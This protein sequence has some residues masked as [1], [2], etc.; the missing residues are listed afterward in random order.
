MQVAR[1]PNDEAERL[2]RLHALAVLDTAPEPVFDALARS[3]ALACEAPIA[4]VSLVDERRQWFKACVGLG[5]NETSRDVAFCSHAI[6]ND[7]LFEIPDATQDPRFAD[8]PL[9]AGEPRI[10]FYAGVPLAMPGGGR[11]GTLC[12][13]DREPRRLD[14]V[15][16]ALLS[17][18]AGAVVHTLVLRERTLDAAWKSRSRLERELDQRA[19]AL[20]AVLDVLPATVGL[21]D[22]GQR[23]QFANAAHETWFDASPDSL[24]GR[25]FDTLLGGA[26]AGSVLSFV[27]RVQAGEAQSFNA[28]LSSPQGSRDVHFHLLPLPAPESGRSG[29]RS[30]V[31]LGNDITAERALLELRE[32]LAAIVQSSGDAI[33][34]TDLRGVI[35]HW[36]AAAQRIFGYPAA[37][38]AGQRLSLLFD[39][40]AGLDAMLSNA[41]LF[42]DGPAAFDSVCRRH[43]GSRLDVSI[44]LAPIRD[45]AGRIG[46][47]SWVVR[48]ISPMKAAE[49]ALRESE[50]KFR[51]LSDSSPV[52]VFHTDPVGLCTY[53]NP[54]WQE[55]YGL[56]LAMSLGDGWAR[57]L[58]PD[59]RF[60]VFET[61]NRAAQSGADFAMEFRI[62]RPDGSVRH[63]RSRSRA[64]H[65]EDGSVSGYVGAVEDVTEALAVQRQLRA[66]EAM[67]DRAGH[68]ARVGGWEVDVGSWLVTWSAQTCRIHDRAPGHQ[69][70][71]A[72]AL[73]HIPLPQR[74]LLD[75]AVRE[76]ITA[77]HP[78]DLELPLVTATGRAIWVRIMG[79]AQRDGGRTVRLFG[80]LQ[81]ITAHRMAQDALRESQQQLRVLYEAT[82]AMLQSM[83][84][85]DRL[86][87]VTDVWLRTLGYRREQVVDTPAQMYF[88]PA[89]RHRVVHDV[90]PELWRRGRVD[91][92]ALQMLASDGRVRDVLLSAVLD[93]NTHSAAQRALV[94]IDD[95]TEDVARR[96]EL[97]REQT[98]R[99]QIESHAEELNQLLRE[100]SEMLDV[101]AHE[102][103]QPLN[104]AS[105]ALQGA[106]AA[107][108]GKGEDAATVRLERAQGVMGQVLAGVDNTLAAASL[109]AG[110]GNLVRTDTDID[111]LVGVT[112][113]DIAQPERGR[114]VVERATTTRTATMDMGLVRLALRNLLANA[115]KYSPPGSPVQLRISESD[116][117]LALVLEV[118]DQ[119]RGFDPAL[120]P[121]LFE[122]GARGVQGGHGLGLYIAR[123]VMDLHGGTIELA[124]STPAGSTLRLI[125]GEAGSI[126]A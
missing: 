49:H 16:R 44:G 15:Q 10:R 50:R 106:T 52:G 102:V 66:S 26:E 68:V 107:L 77:G 81:D 100:R 36:N 92:V 98:L 115:L 39:A 86:L 58:H 122:R 29:P 73:E 17:E 40:E 32:R 60:E 31:S 113:A 110:S 51:V 19:R 84:A 37:A 56:S 13:I 18:L 114:I 64:V 4:L 27:E 61:W 121:R 22:A 28:R 125:I 3:A 8:N 7:A 99:R 55:I 79:E 23:N 108:A 59:D 126:D 109:L 78:F 25:K 105:A 62:Q 89:S 111:T 88:A 48:D 95:V 76:C 112:I 75:A 123:R 38:V 57:T 9:V 82:P 67:L 63:V 119:G 90:F 30:F 43:D 33:I 41:K 94:F 34:G 65:A 35:E 14:D 103:R 74:P 116:Q 124:R 53:T 117:P 91:S 80:A 20:A 46:G 71:L 120:V 118:H 83:D 101:L 93:P 70:S 104:N 42:D 5:V 69:P 96:A 87:T 72:E 97:Q 54:C 85:H 1:L 24:R 21:W 45:E 2:A 47:V 12:V 11:I 6:L